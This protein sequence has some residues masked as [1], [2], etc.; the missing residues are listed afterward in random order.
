MHSI[1]CFG[2][3][4]PTVGHFK[5]LWFPLAASFSQRT[6]KAP[7]PMWICSGSLAQSLIV[8][9]RT[10]PRATGASESASRCHWQWAQPQMK[11]TVCGKLCSFVCRAA[12]ASHP[13]GSRPLAQV[14]S[15][16]EQFC[17]HLCQLSPPCQGTVIVSRSDHLAA[18]QRPFSLPTNPCAESR[19]AGAL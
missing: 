16:V 4:R 10:S 19:S 8:P 3:S 6:H 2:G 1:L 12:S 9:W 18:S 17:C 15:Y 5:C 14:N 7:A 11:L 13:R